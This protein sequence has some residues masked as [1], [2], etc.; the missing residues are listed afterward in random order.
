MT[1]LKEK[2]KMV[3]T[4]EIGAAALAQVE[5]ANRRQRDAVVAGT[6]LR[7]FGDFMPRLFD[8]VDKAYGDGELSQ[9]TA[10]LLKDYMSE[11]VGELGQRQVALRNEKVLLEGESRAL[12]RFAV[13][14]AKKVQR[15]KLRVDQLELEE[16]EI[17]KEIEDEVNAAG[18]CDRHDTVNCVKCAVDPPTDDTEKSVEAAKEVSPPEPEKPPGRKR[19]GR[20]RRAKKAATKP[21]PPSDGQ[22][23]IDATDS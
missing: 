7:A 2:L 1:A 13:G 11:I 20:K 14:V 9:E 4:S 19:T 18:K 6:A 10:K 23:V 12:Q 8:R 21:E 15:M 22:Q 16:A 5:D 17:A 3:A